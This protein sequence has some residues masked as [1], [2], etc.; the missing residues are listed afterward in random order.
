[1]I[2]VMLQI[3]QRRDGAARMVTVPWTGYA[4]A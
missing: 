2:V 1:M 4:L 3:A